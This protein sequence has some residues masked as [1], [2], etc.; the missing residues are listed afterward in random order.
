M[1]TRTI[2]FIVVCVVVF[3]GSIFGAYA[4]KLRR[5]R[6]AA[7]KAAAEAE[8]LLNP[9][10]LAF[11]RRRCFER[12]PRTG[13]PSRPSPGARA[14]IARNAA[15]ASA[16]E[17][18]KQR[19]GRLQAGTRCGKVA[20]SG[21]VKAKRAFLADDLAALG[22]AGVAVVE[23][24]PSLPPR[25]ASRDNRAYVAN[26]APPRHERFFYLS[27]DLAEL[28]GRATTAR[29]ARRSTLDLE[30][31]DQRRAAA[32]GDDRD[33]DRERLSFDTW[34]AKAATKRDLARGA[35][36]AQRATPAAAGEVPSS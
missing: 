14:A 21:R 31:V 29:R 18:A 25:A 4:I 6:I 33:G 20:A 35:S 13:R 36:G 17:A 12:G 15:A 24:A 19:V 27:H 30:A 10:A 22:V 3:V 26:Q 7:E 9:P 5:E 34:P 16:L 28:A 8:P 2:A 1:S 11:W 32:G 23:E